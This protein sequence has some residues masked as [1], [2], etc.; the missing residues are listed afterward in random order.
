[1]TRS[2]AVNRAAR[3]PTADAGAAIR[4]A[5]ARRGRMI[6]FSD[7]GERLAQ[8]AAFLAWLPPEVHAAPAIAWD[9]LPGEVM[10][11]LIHTT[12]RD[13]DAIPIALGIGVLQ[14]VVSANTMFTHAA[15]LTILL[16]RLRQDA[17][18]RALADL[19]ER[20]IWE[21]FVAHHA[22]GT[23]R[24][25]A[26]GCPLPP[27]LV[28]G[29]ATYETISGKHLPS[30]LEERLGTA[31]RARWQA[32]LD[33]LGMDPSPRWQDCILPAQPSQFMARLGLRRAETISARLRRKEQTDI[34]TPLHGLLVQ[35]GLL[36]KQAME[37]LVQAY[38]S[39]LAGL[40][41]RG[42]M[43]TEHLPHTFEHRAIIP[44]VN[45]DAASL[46]EVEVEGRE[47][48]LRLTIWDRRS[49]AT[50]HPE[51]LSRQIR[52]HLRRGVGSFA[53]TRNAVFLQCHTAAEDLLWFGEIVANQVLG[54]VQL[55]G[56]RAR[57]AATQRLGEERGFYVKRPGLLSPGQADGTWF[58]HNVV[59]GELVFE[60]ESL[61]RGV[62]YA[63]CL[64]TIALTAGL[65]VS[66]LLQI[67]EERWDVVVVPQL[68]RGVPTGRYD[69]IALQYV[70]PKG[71]ATEQDRQ[72]KLICAQAL[73]L[74]Q[75]I[76][77]ALT[78]RHGRIPTVRPHGGKKYHLKAEPYYF[79]WD[80]SD[81]GQVG[82][83][84]G[85]D[86]GRLLRFLFHGLDLSTADGT[87][88]RLAAHLCRHVLATTAIHT[89]RVP[90]EA[91]AW[92]LSHRL[93]NA[94][95]L[96]HAMPDATHYYSEQ[97]RERQLA[98]LHEL[99]TEIATQSRT[100]G[101]RPP[102]T[103]DLAEMD[104]ALREVFENFGTI[105]PTALG[106]CGAGMCIRPGNRALCIGCPFLVEDYHRLPAAT[107]WRTILCQ[108][109]AQLEEDGNATE[110]RQRQRE[111][112]LLDGHMTMMR[113]QQ[114]TVEAGGA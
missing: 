61:Y 28:H 44:L 92:L 46:K 33:A 14:G 96:P 49:W 40:H 27:G 103:K 6:N 45:R 86:V 107:R 57:L 95:S 1:M 29:L 76:G 112:D 88:I 63:S 50:A 64:A 59:R 85:D 82:M 60:P 81:D 51:R 66:E 75:E 26:R 19:D 30:Y 3:G 71:Y 98:I 5:G 36:R 91:V 7:P 34:V 32:A 99:Q 54:T 18:L 21:R 110:A 114:R 65:R 83:L 104:A 77:A 109:I 67:S 31:G 13:A 12:G 93:T 72:P 10:G 62:L 102:T 38:R 79:Q 2:E 101:L 58:A 80:A 113:L 24:A 25:H 22:A 106:Y 90:P 43:L 37:R 68:R 97:P 16:R 73:P 35:L 94:G 23:A 53:P 84:Y 11:Y 48:V 47:R 17:G 111:L 4:S 9:Q 78:A 87:P 8:V 69:K 39:E 55:A 100:Y 52:A 105:G 41:A 108:Q 89:H 56:N 70:L 20:A 42:G 74:L 15:S